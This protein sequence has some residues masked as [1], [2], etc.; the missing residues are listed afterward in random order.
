MVVYKK[1]GDYLILGQLPDGEMYLDR[2]NSITVLIAFNVMLFAVIFILTAMLVQRVVISGI[3]KVNRSLGLI[4][5]GDLTEVVNVCTNAE[6]RSLSN[7]IN[8]MVGALKAAINEV[9]SRID[10][11]LA[12]AN[13]VQLSV[14]PANSPSFQEG[15]SVYG[16]MYAA[17]K[18]GG[19]FYDFFMI[20]KHHLCI[21]IADVSDKGIPAALFMMQSKSLIKSFA[22]TGLPVDEVFIKSN[23]ALCEN[24]GANMFVTA[25]IGTL[26]LR[27]GVLEHCNAGH[28]PPLIK[29]DRL[30]YQRLPSK[31]GFVLAGMPD[32]RYCKN[33]SMLKKGDKLFLYTDGITEAMNREGKLYGEN[34]MTD[35]L[36]SLAADMSL[37]DLITAVKADVDR[38]A[39]GA[40]QAD[41]ITMLAI[42]YHGKPEQE[43]R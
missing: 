17:K 23:N 5:K 20:D 7:G 24:N 15:L 31:C 38:F 28:N 39:D 40:E 21:V 32:M 8:T 29:T 30:S 19:D 3:Q 18:I 42:E 1:V 16:G 25:F 10:S 2:D 9:A 14:L 13:A 22:L 43:S 27:T 26:D 11:E 6:F 34:R 41:D 35:F 37:E 36:N 12:F 4:T 33:Q